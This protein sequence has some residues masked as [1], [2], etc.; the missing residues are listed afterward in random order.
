MPLY[1]HAARRPLEQKRTGIPKSFSKPS[2]YGNAVGRIMVHESTFLKREQIGRM[3][4]MDFSGAIRVLMETVYASY[5]QGARL[6]HEVEEGLMRFL[7][8]EYHF[9]D[10]TSRGT[11]VARF[12][13]LKY[14][15]HN[16]RVLLKRHHLAG[17]GGD[18]VISELGTVPETDMLDAI[19]GR[20]PARQLPDQVQRV[21]DLTAAAMGE[22]PDPQRIDSI[23]DRAFLEERLDVAEHERSQLLVAFSQAAIDLANLRVVLRGHRLE[24]GPGFYEEALARGGRLSRSRL[25][26]MAVEPFETVTDR[27]LES[28]YGKMLEPVLSRSEG[29]VRLTYL[30]KESDEYL[31]DQVRLFWRVSVGPERI[32]KYMLTRE[33]EVAMLR[34][35]LMGKL[36]GLTPEAI[37]ARLP[38]AYLYDESGR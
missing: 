22:G 3:T 7:A 32:V 29:R 15:F 25:L 38:A 35:I 23:V 10:E 19:E 36:H 11:L 24:K 31:L 6:S 26:A 2:R 27:L 8:D 13:H 28:R 20:R 34:V 30:D 21:I 1:E 33:N 16:L 9:L 5:L 12:M 18:E 14:D 4:Q 17:A 37:S